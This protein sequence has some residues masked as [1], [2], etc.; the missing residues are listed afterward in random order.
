[1]LMREETILL[2]ELKWE[3]LLLS[4]NKDAYDIACRICGV[5]VDSSFWS[6]DY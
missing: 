3:M 6:L 2:V 5:L 4:C 1:M